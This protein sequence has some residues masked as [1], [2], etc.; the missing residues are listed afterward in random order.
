M[1]ISLL[2]LSRKKEV[3]K[4]IELSE[5]AEMIRENPE[6]DRVI[7]SLQRRRHKTPPSPS[8]PSLVCVTTR[9]RPPRW[10]SVRPWRSLMTASPWYPTALYPRPGQRLRPLTG[11]EPLADGPAESD[12]LASELLARLLPPASPDPLRLSAPYTH[13]TQTDSMTHFFAYSLIR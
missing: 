4:R 8:L 10:D 2:K 9:V 13:Q 7:T 3:I 11:P 6:K 5:L 1:K 12:C